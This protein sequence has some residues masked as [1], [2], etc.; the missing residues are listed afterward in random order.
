MV[1]WAHDCSGSHGNNC[2]PLWMFLPRLKRMSARKNKHITTT[3]HGNKHVSMVKHVARGWNL[4]QVVFLVFFGWDMWSDPTS[5]SYRERL[6]M[7]H[8]ST[9]FVFNAIIHQSMMS[10]WRFLF[11]FVVSPLPGEMM[12]FD[13]HIFQMGW[14]HQLIILCQKNEFNL[15]FWPLFFSCM[16]IF[17]RAALYWCNE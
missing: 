14:N 2:F 12:Q 16:N 9:K 13:E 10:R 15:N 3:R 17:C 11:Y 5:W 4:S 1:L 6:R 8:Q 7:F